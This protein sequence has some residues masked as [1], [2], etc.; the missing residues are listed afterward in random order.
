MIKKLLIT[1]VVLIAVMGTAIFLY[2]YQILRYSAETIIRKILPDY[3][4]IDGINFDFKGKKIVLSGFKITNPPGFSQP[5]LVSIDKISCLYAM[6]GKSVL[7]GLEVASPALQGLLLNIERLRDG[8]LNI[9]EMDKVFNKTK[10][11]APQTAAVS[12]KA[13]AEGAVSSLM[14]D[15]KISDIIKLPERFSVN[16]GKMIFVDKFVGTRPHVITFE[17][18]SADLLLQ[19]DDS[20][21]RALNIASTGEGSINGNKR[22]RLEWNVG[23]NPAIPRLTMS[24]RFVVS[25]VELLTFEPYYDKYSP[26]IFKSGRFSGTLVFD[27]DNGNIGSTNEVHLSGISFLIKRGYE[28]AAFWETNVE[29]LAKYFTSPSGDI[30]FDFKIKGD[31]SKPSFYLG[32]ISKQAIASMA[33]DKIS[34]AIESASKQGGTGTGGQSDLDK[35]KG[36]IDMFKGLIDKNR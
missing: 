7:D 12:K 27:F 25:G 23:F 15:R 36:Y 2:R 16:N 4:K 5:Y 30:V 18:I 10:S 21:T 11:A 32:P 35:A 31:M 19:L 20:Y 8:R 13:G 17:N 22:E 28:G 6:K 34:Q 3:V 14:G 33:I 26:F 9:T 29:D 24:N 1:I